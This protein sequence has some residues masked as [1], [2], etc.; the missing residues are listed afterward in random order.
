MKKTY[1]TAKIV[2]N[3]EFTTTSTVSQTREEIRGKVGIDIRPVD[4]GI[5]YQIVENN[6]KIG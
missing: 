1:S 5:G 2:F 4:G 6:N 3:K